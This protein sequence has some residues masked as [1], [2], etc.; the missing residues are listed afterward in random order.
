[1]NQAQFPTFAPRGH[2][3]AEKLASYLYEETLLALGDAKSV[4]TVLD[5]EED[6]WNS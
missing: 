5:E 1:M 2:V 6:L 3:P 4:D